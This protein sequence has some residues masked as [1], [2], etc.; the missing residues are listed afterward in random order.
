MEGERTDKK[1]VCRRGRKQQWQEKHYINKYKIMIHKERLRIA[2]FPSVI[3]LCELCIQQ[4]TPVT[5]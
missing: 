5:T 1:T 2:D 4:N 3:V